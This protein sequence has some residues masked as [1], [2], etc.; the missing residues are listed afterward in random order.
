MTEGEDA[1]LIDRDIE[2]AATPED[3][4]AAHAD[5]VALGMSKCLPGIIKSFDPVNQTVTVQPA[6]KR[7]FGGESPVDLPLCVDVPVVF[8]SGG[9]LVMTFPIAAGDECLLFFADRAIDNW[10]DRGGTQEP[11]EHRLHDLSDGFA[12]VGVSS[13][14][15]FLS[16]E[17]NGEA[18]EI[19]TRDGSVIFRAVAPSGG[20]SGSGGGAVEAAVLSE[21]LLDAIAALTVPTGMGPSG[22]PINIAQFKNTIKS[23]T[24]FVGP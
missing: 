4:A 13:R 20:G 7:I 21:K 9:G 24:A 23:L 22:T 1:D 8:P 12:L 5:A 3:A 19:R 2:R 11:S 14:P 10:W 15:R 16:P 6:I 18:I 17:V